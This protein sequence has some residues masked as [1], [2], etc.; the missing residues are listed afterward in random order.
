VVRHA[1]AEVPVR[2]SATCAAAIALWLSL[3][4]ADITTPSASP[5]A[6]PSPAP[7]LSASDRAL[8]ALGEE[9]VVVEGEAPR[10]TTASRREVDARTLAATPRRSADDVLRLVPGLHLSQ[11][12]AEGKAQQLFLRGFDAVHGA[13]VAVGVAGMPINEPSNVHGHGYVD[14]GFV[15]PEAITLLRGRKGS[16][17]VDQGD[18][19]TAGSVDLEL[20]ASA[21]G[22]RVGAE[23]G[24]TGRQRVVGVVAP[25]AGPEAEVVAIEAM[26]DDGYGQN[27]GSERVSALAQTRLGAGGW[28]V[29][30]LVA[31]YAARFGEPGV[32]PL[33]DV[34]RG[35]LDF[36]DTYARDGRGTSQRVLASL[37][38]GRG[39]GEQRLDGGLWLGWRGLS[40]DENFTGWLEDPVMGDRRLQQ[41]RA[42][43][44]GGS[45][46][47]R[48]RIGA[49]AIDAGASGRV[50]D[51]GQRE[52][53]LTADGA[54]WRA[55]RDLAGT[56]LAG[57]VWAGATWRPGRWRL[58]AGARG[59]AFAL[60]ADDHLDDARDGTGTLAALSPRLS[61]SWQ[62]RLMS[63]FA[64]YGRGLRSP[65]VRSVGVRS[66]RADMEATFYEG[67]APEVTRS[68]T[69]EVGARWRPAAGLDVGGAGFATRITREAVFDHLSGVNAAIDESRR[70]G[71]ELDAAWT[72]R[73]GLELRA[74][75]TFVDA[76]FAV[77]GNPVPGAPRIM[78]SVEARL[79]RGPWTASVVTRHLGARPLAHGATGTA[80]TVVDALAAYRRGGWEVSL[81]ID[82][83]LGADWR[84][85]EYHIA[86]WWDP[87]QPR[88]SLPRL[89]Y[90]AGRPLGGRLALT[91]WL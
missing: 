85:G 9:V 40:L 83:A 52:D 79:W 30:P 50:D 64:A 22:S 84:E 36:L 58:A 76:R 41:H 38:A 43:A 29:T 91:R 37:R 88:S 90:A 77:S 4:G 7:P 45:L 39:D 56:V 55:R 57:G 63:L 87:S 6:A 3:A 14:L 49:I 20:G 59:D 68:D 5:S 31:A 24:T 47:G 51:L 61:A 71:V 26:R 62:G 65:E 11:H 73:P 2:R 78:A 86:S 16:F 42:L 34:R 44:S 66:E 67:G 54:P 33:E 1:D 10:P 12:G 48:W 27:R 81:Q 75:A 60:D 46:G 80:S 25:E 18:F 70:L 74:D 13:D 53:G 23:V 35:R 21:R 32:V 69:G 15:I 28:S 17:D 72:A 89:H 82:N 8:L 19:A